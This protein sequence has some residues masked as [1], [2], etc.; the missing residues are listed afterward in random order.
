MS[1]PTHPLGKTGTGPRVA[2]VLLGL[3]LLLVL[4]R[5]LPPRG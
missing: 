5:S 1:L 2:L 4:G 3:A